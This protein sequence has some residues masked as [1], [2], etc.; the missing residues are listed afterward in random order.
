M[1][2]L[3]V[4]L[5]NGITMPQLGLGV[6]QA[7]DGAE[8]EAAVT[9]AIDAGYRLI[10]TAAVYGNEAGVGRA[11]GGSVVP[12]EEL[13][14]TTKLWNAD[15]GYEQT[16]EAFDKSLKRLGLDYI[17]LYLIH[18]PVP[19]KDTYLETWRA[20]EK[21]YSDGKVKAIGVSNFTP[22]YLE[23]LL[24]ES[25]VA[26]AVNQI[27]LH[28]RFNQAATREFCH[29]HGIAVESYSPLGGST[30]NLVNDQTLSEI[31][32]TYGKTAAQVILRWHLQQGLIVIPKSVRPERIAQ[33]FAV[34]DFE[35]S[36]DDMKKIDDLNTDERVGADPVTANFT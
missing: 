28:P 25:T 13:F 18:W 33:N 6:W 34:F 30:S 27:E 8:V 14:I 36:E 24:A 7:K 1:P 32:K 10:D 9:A 4:T 16:L 23:R 11:V 5:N 17:D 2:Q 26:P 20:F 15:Q 21:L 29:A 19:A 31:G 12:R 3:Q 35:L 22:E